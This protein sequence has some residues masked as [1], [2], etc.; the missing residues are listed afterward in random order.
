MTTIKSKIPVQTKPFVSIGYSSKKQNSEYFKHI[1]GYFDTKSE[2]HV[3][4]RLIVCYKKQKDKVKTDLPKKK[5]FARKL[6]KSKGKNRKCVTFTSPTTSGEKKKVSHPSKGKY[7][8][9]AGAEKVI[10]HTRQ[11][12]NHLHLNNP[13]ESYGSM[14]S[15]TKADF[16]RACTCGDKFEVVESY[17]KRRKTKKQ[18][19]D[20]FKNRLKQD[21]DDFF[22]NTE[23]YKKRSTGGT[24]EYPVAKVEAAS[25]RGL[26]STAKS[27]WAYI[28]PLVKGYEPLKLDKKDGDREVQYIFGTARTSDYNMTNPNLISTAAAK[29]MRLSMFTVV[30]T[31][32]TNGFYSVYIRGSDFF[33]DNKRIGPT[34][35]S[36]KT[37]HYL[38]FGKN[39]KPFFR[40]VVS[41]PHDYRLLNLKFNLSSK[42]IIK[43]K[44]HF[45]NMYLVESLL[46]DRPEANKKQT[47]KAFSYK[48]MD[49]IALQVIKSVSSDEEDERFDK[50]V[51]SEVVLLQ[52]NLV[53]KHILKLLDYS[54]VCDNLYLAFPLYKFGTLSDRIKKKG[55][56]ILQ[57]KVFFNQILSALYYLHR[58]KIVHGAVYPC[59]VLLTSDESVCPIKLCN[60]SYA[61]KGSK[62][63]EDIVHGNI[64]YLAPEVV[65]G[66]EWLT[67]NNKADIWSFGVSLFHCLADQHPFSDSPFKTTEDNTAVI[68]K[69]CS[70][71]YD[72]N[73][74]KKARLSEDS[75]KFV[76]KILKKSPLSRPNSLQL[77]KEKWLADDKARSI[78]ANFNSN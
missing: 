47:Y 67:V 55:L 20:D 12:C 53:C 65:R 71:D 76:E 64:S 48:S 44:N 78:C 26:T 35:V 51:K 4:T 72:I 1:N 36:L 25:N 54:H 22:L 39:L 28:Q 16:K 14:D 69:I 9:Q 43:Y 57:I 29:R 66:N 37:I 59:H 15:I 70:V 52:K 45:V 40:I 23:K 3:F 50:E 56:S 6:N 27:Y 24:K 42:N 58:R 8:R 74:L 61:F 73:L 41:P 30:K 18:V 77:S 62:K 46:V 5:R 7:D 75:C 68:K 31:A 2:I 38:S 19:K 17:K 49:V 33:V 60:F 21:M 11:S 34:K 32:E 10:L 13:L 63:A